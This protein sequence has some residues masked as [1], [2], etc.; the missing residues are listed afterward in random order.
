MIETL[1]LIYSTIVTHD[2]LERESGCWHCFWC[3][4]LAVKY[5]QCKQN[6]TINERNNLTLSCVFESSGGNSYT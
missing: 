5:D 1:L 3:M 4:L 6:M 2:V